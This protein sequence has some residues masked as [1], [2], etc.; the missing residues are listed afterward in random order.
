MPATDSKAKRG[1]RETE[2]SI[3][4]AAHVKPSQRRT[5]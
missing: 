1:A 5:T 2:T 3:L 4:G